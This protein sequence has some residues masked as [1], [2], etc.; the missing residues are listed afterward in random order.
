MSIA[1]PS[2]LVIYTP[3][4]LSVVFAITRK[5]TLVMIVAVHFEAENKLTELYAF[6]SL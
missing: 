1:F 5:L 4:I 3:V 2:S 6:R